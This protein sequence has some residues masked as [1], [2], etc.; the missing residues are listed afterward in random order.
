MN[1]TRIPDP[2]LLLVAWIVLMIWV[3][4]LLGSV[5]VFSLWFY[6]Y[7]FDLGEIGNGVSLY[8]I[9]TVFLVGFV[10]VF[11]AWQYWHR[12]VVTKRQVM[13]RLSR[14]EFDCSSKLDAILARR[15]DLA[16]AV[17]FKNPFLNYKPGPRWKYINE[18]GMQLVERIGDFLPHY[19]RTYGQICIERR[20]TDS[21]EAKMVAARM[22][23]RFAR[24]F[25]DRPVLAAA[26]AGSTNRSAQF[27]LHPSVDGERLDFCLNIGS[28]IGPAYLD[29]LDEMINASG[30]DL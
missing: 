30:A 11:G 23:E 22:Q 4:M 27:Q 29:V 19:M 1:E 20:L 16:V 3:P 8:G 5:L 18:N 25:S 15:S 28:W 10:L 7:L 14:Q 26:L 12:S 9:A 17:E 24:F 21:T 2:F 13:E 6:D